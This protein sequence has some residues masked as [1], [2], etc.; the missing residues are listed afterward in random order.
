MCHC[1]LSTGAAPPAVLAINRPDRVRDAIL[2]G[3]PLLEKRPFFSCPSTRMLAIL[4]HIRGEYDRRL[5]VLSFR[6]G[7]A[8][9]V[10]Y[11][12]LCREGDD[13]ARVIMHETRARFR[14][15]SQARHVVCDRGG[16][17]KQS[18][19][20]CCLKDTPAPMANTH[21]TGGPYARYL[22]QCCSGARP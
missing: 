16:R 22:L 19:Q 3:L 20:R 11:P 14:T 5:V 10:I 6:K 2:V 12:P 13:G 1:Q 18:Q 21:R 4:M 9:Q 17:S 8:S 15:L 7:W